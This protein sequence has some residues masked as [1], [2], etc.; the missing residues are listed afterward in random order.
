MKRSKAVTPASARQ[1]ERTAMAR[2]IVLLKAERYA[3]ARGTTRAK[4]ER[5]ADEFIVALDR[6]ARAI[7]ASASGRR[8]Q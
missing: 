4:R 7:R 1:R 2:A 5:A 8:G 6:Y 3:D